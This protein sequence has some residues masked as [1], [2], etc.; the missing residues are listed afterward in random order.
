MKKRSYTGPRNIDEDNPYWV[1]FSDLMSGL[2]VIFILASVALIIELTQ[3]TNDVEMG[4][5]L[6]KQSKRAV[7]SFMTCEM[8]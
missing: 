5:R 3:R 4:K 7:T 6:K 1:S 2:L 8:N